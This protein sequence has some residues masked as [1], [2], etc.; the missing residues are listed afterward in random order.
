MVTKVLPGTPP[1]EVGPGL[2]LTRT[3]RG[4][5]LFGDLEQIERL[6]EEKGWK[7]VDTGQRVLKKE[8]K[9]GKTYQLVQGGNVS[10]GVSLPDAEL[11]VA[12]MRTPKLLRVE[13]P[14]GIFPV[15]TA[16]GK[17]IVA[18]PP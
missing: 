12:L 2:Y 13:T 14:E 15:F 16:G 9:Q 4:N 6:A 18:I 3:S 5:V 10:L 11:G 8:L 7:I 1:K 17:A